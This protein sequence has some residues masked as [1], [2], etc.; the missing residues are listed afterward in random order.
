MSLLD[1]L[2]VEQTYGAERE[3]RRLFSEETGITFLDEGTHTSR[4]ENG[5]LLRVYAVHIHHH[6][7]VEAFNIRP[8]LATTFPFAMWIS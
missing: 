2:L 4:L 1:P 7:A 6:T 5:A 8:T 3:A